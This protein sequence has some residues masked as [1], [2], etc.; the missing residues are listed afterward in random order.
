MT[1]E[2]A[3]I[4]AL[5]AALSVTAHNCNIEILLCAAQEI[6]EWLVGKADKGNK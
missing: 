1:E 4:K 6:Y 2:I 3:R 5:D